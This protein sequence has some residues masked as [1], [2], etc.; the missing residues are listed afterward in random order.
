MPPTTLENCKA[1]LATLECMECCGQGLLTHQGGVQRLL[2]PGMPN[3][4]WGS[5]RV[6]VTRGALEEYRGCRGQTHPPGCLKEC[7][8]HC[9]QGCLAHPGGM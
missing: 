7:K 5:A 1:T 2:W 6:A 3:L 9:G 4:T 8:G